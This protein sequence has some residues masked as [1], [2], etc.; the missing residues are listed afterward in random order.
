VAPSNLGV[1]G[2]YV[3]V[4]EVFDLLASQGPGAKG[5]IQ[6]TDAIESLRR[7]R[8]VL[9]L[10]FQGV[11]YDTGDKMGYLKATVDFALR[12]PDLGQEF[13]E[14]LRERAASLEAPKGA[15]T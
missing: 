9:A 6:L 10:E 12:H 3:L 15:S 1:V 5:E 4:P 8:R 7:Q 13:A 2:R 14:F 11:R